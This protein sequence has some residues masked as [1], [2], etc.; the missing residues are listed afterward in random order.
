MC[1]LKLVWE[2][3]S[4]ELLIL[5]QLPVFVPVKAVPQGAAQKQMGYYRQV[6]Q[7]WN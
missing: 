1:I 4:V 3:L 2:T 6:T 5:I 7:E